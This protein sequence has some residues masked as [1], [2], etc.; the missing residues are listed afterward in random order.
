MQQFR[1]ACV[2]CSVKVFHMRK[3]LSI[4]LAS[5]LLAISMHLGIASHFCRGE[6]AQAK[7]VYGFG[8]ASC[9][10]DCSIPAN[11]PNQQEARF[12]KLSCCQDFIFSI[13]VDEYQTVSQKL[14]TEN[15]KN[16]SP[17][18][19]PVYI[20]DLFVLNTTYNSIPPPPSSEVFLP[21]IQ[22]F[23]I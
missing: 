18:T 2:Y 22:V 7:V 17:K 9:G 19:N 21:F 23:L 14:I 11:D 16:I 15:H 8:E 4:L 1:P 5:L 3:S 13:A 6:L 10:M 20:E 12:Q